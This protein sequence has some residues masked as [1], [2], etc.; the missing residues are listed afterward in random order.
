MTPE[1]IDDPRD[2]AAQPSAAANPAGASRL[3]S[4]RP[5]RRVAELGSLEYAEAPKY[6]VLVGGGCL[7]GR[8][9]QHLL[10]YFH[11]GTDIHEHG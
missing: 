7:C 3:Q 1:R 9:G 11:G 10:R 4:L 6:L 5:V 2:Q 8:R